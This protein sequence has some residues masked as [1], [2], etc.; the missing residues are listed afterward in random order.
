MRL[1]F[2]ILFATLAV[3]VDSDKIRY[4]GH[5]VYRISPKTKGQEEV[6]LKLGKSRSYNF[7]TGINNAGL[8]V[9]IMVKPEDQDAFKNEISKN[10]MN[11]DV[12]IEDVQK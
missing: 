3:F 9:D 10:G 2:L 1:I 11:P 4:D 6:L 7:W 12:Y 5:K 8:P